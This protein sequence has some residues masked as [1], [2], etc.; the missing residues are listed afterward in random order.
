[1][2]NIRGFKY[3]FRIENGRVAVTEGLD[4]LKENIIQIIKTRPGEILLKPDWGCKINNRVF[5]PVNVSSLATSDIKT[6]IEKYEPRVTIKNIEVGYDQASQGI[7][8]LSIL[9]TPKGQDNNTAEVLVT[10]G[11]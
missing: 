3:P 9:F 7:L 5:D 4:K 8:T 10:M 11:S 1:M 2:L 6:A